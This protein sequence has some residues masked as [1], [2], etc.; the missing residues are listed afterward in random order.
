M[1]GAL[2]ASSKAK[3]ILVIEDD[4]DLSFI[5]KRRLQAIR[6]GDSIQTVKTIYAAVTTFQADPVDFIFLDLNLPDSYGI[7]SVKDIRKYNKNVPIVVTTG[8]A[9]ELTIEEAMKHGAQ[10]LILKSQITKEYLEEALRRYIG[11]AEAVAEGGA[12]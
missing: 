4:S 11:P 12:A 1:A 7:S 2:N 3:R 6:P 8:L 9:N 10:E 5:M